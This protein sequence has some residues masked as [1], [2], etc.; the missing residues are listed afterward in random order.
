MACNSAGYS[1]LPFAQGFEIF[2]AKLR[3]NLAVSLSSKVLICKL[4]SQF[5]FSAASMPTYCAEK[6]RL[7]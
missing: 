3:P 1:L 2:F 7:R 4:L 5:N 6:Y